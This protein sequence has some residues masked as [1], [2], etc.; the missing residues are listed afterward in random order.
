M[1]QTSVVIFRMKQPHHCWHAKEECQQ[2]VFQHDNML[3]IGP[4]L[5]KEVGRVL[6]LLKGC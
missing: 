4:L 3:G 2:F 5:M 1:Y 6:V